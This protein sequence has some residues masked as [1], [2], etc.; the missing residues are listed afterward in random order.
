MLLS[1][2]RLTLTS[3]MP[4]AGR[5]ADDEQPALG[6]QRAQGVG[7][8]VAAHHV[9]HDVRA[10]AAGELEHRVLEAVEQHRLVGTGPRGE[11]RLLLGAGHRDDA[12]AEALGHLDGRGADTPGRAVHDDRLA[13]LQPAALDE[14]EVGGQVVHRQRRALVVRDVVGE[15]EDRHRRRHHQ[16]GGPAV[17]QHAGDPLTRGVALRPAHHGAGEVDAERERRLGAQLV[18]GPC[19]AAGRGTRSPP[20]APRPAPRRP[21]APGR[22]PPPRARRRDRWA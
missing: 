19:S 22:A 13:L 11:G 10:L 4:G 17:R 6:A 16:L 5:E 8:H 15:A 1:S 21:A 9:E 20:G 18:L 3:G 14:R 12:R 2:S 7:E